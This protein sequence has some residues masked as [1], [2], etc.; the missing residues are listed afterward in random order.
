MGLLDGILGGSIDD[1][2]TGAVASM[3]QGLLSS[4][5]ALGGMSQGLLGYQDQMARAKQK[6]Q[7]EQMQAMQ[8]Q[9]QQ[10]QLK[11][12]QQQVARQ[13]A[14]RQQMGQ[15]GGGQAPQMDMSQPRMP[16]QSMALMPAENQRRQALQPMQPPQSSQGSPNE[17]LVARLNQMGNI[18]A[19]NGDNEGANK[20]FEQAAKLLPKYGTEPRYDQTGQAFLASDNGQIKYLDGVQARDELVADNLNNKLSYRT[21]YDPTPIGAQALGN[22]PDALL[23]AG[24]TRRGQDMTDGRARDFNAQ[25]KEGQRVQIIN[26]PV[27]G[28]TLVDKGTGLAR[29]AVGL[30]G[31]AMPSESATKAAKLGGQL[32]AAIPMARDLLKTATASGAGALTDIAGNFFGANSKSAESA[33]Q[34]ETLSG[35][36]VANVPRMEGPQS[37][38]DVANYQ[39]MAAQVGNRW[40]PAAQ[41]LSA[42]NTLEE[43]HKKYAALNS[44]GSAKAE[45]PWSPASAGGGVRHY[46]PATGKLE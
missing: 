6:Q 26:D 4:P 2:R 40:A 9:Q 38:A 45:S 34:L 3:V 20:Y 16:P 10:M 19:Q 36:M 35:W 32:T 23:S 30:N 13:E 25:N 21:K 41:R 17:A 12:M 15:M 33:A 18:Y 14:I 44:S 42:L 37:N 31:Q 8:M 1:P 46:N 5:N 11:Q 24:T 27:N 7:M 43:L 29:P 39:T 22:S 28:I